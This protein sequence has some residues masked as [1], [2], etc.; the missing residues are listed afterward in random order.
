[1][2]E[3]TKK[4]FQALERQQKQYKRQNDYIKENYFRTTITI[5]R[6]IAAIVKENE[7]SFNGYVTELIKRDLI[8]RK[9]LPDRFQD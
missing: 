7:K 5:D 6:N 8:E 1:M 9:L 2:D 3:K 4:A